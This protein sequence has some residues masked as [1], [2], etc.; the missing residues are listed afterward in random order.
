MKLRTAA[1]LKENETFTYQTKKGIKT[2]LI[3]K[4]VD[5]DEHQVIE[6]HKNC[7]LVITDD[8][9]QIVVNKDCTL[10]NT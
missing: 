4:I 7:I 3:K 1:D 10:I 5:L 6:K 9:K 2:V 8:C